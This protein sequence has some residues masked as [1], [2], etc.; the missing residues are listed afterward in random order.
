MKSATAG[1]LSPTQ[2]QSGKLCPMATRSVGIQPVEDE[3]L[4][5]RMD[6]Q[7]AASMS[8]DEARYLVWLYY[9]MQKN[10][11]AA[12]NR[13]RALKTRGEPGHSLAF[14]ERQFLILE[15]QVR[16]I[17]A[18][19]GCKFPEY[20]WAVSI[21]GI[22][23]VLAAGLQSVFDV[24]GRPRVSSFWRFAGLD[25]TLEWKP[26]QKRPFSAQA[27]VLAWKIGESF[28]KFSN[29]DQCWYGKL[30]REKWEYYK[31]RNEAGD[32]AARALERA[33]RVARNTEAYKFYAAGKL[34]PAHV[35]AM[36]KRWVAKLFLAHYHHVCHLVRYGT[37]PPQPYVIARLGHATFIEPPNLD[38]LSDGSD[39]T[40]SD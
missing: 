39:N 13:L 25:P 33:S 38:T 16:R 10:R 40:K 36:A 3:L 18:Q 22:G 26:G 32:Y 30:L 23:P 27:K 35:L 15:T 28:L 20:R 19:W 2:G 21:Y 8:R 14:I 24:E 17:L 4:L 5:L 1:P 9:A 12:G 11:L 34:P 37:P 6:A 29:R 7:L 31:A